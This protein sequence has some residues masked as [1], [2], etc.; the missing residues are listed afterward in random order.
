MRIISFILLVV[1]GFNVYALKP[2]SVYDIT[3]TFYGLMYKDFKIPT[4]DSLILQSWFVPSQKAL[5]KD[6][7]LSIRNNKERQKYNASNSFAN[8]TIIIT[9]GDAVNM[10]Q[11]VH[12]VNILSTNGFNVI[13]FDWRGF[14]ESSRWEIDERM[15]IYEE[16][17]EDYNSAIDFIIQMP[18]VDTSRLGVYGF[19]TGAYMAFVI[20]SM[21]PEIKALAGRA[22]FTS[23]P[24]LMGNIN[25]LFP[26]K[27]ITIKEDFDE[28]YNALKLAHKITQPIF[29]IIGKEDKRTPPSMSEELL[30]AVNSDVRELWI[31]NNCGHGGAEAPEYLNRA[32]HFKRL[33]R[34][35]SENLK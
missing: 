23:Y 9:T 35:Y 19:S 32:E 10:C 6:S 29:L 4:T 17:I 30:S 22:F 26:A 2:D 21:R 18:E 8:P 3:P 16:F 28:K 31:V 15:V 7:I 33:M 34:F 13:T 1:F 12:Y 27:K 20:S 11:L 25:T 14:G 24:V 5:S